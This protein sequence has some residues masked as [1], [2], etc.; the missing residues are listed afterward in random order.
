MTR[1]AFGAALA[2]LV[3][4]APPAGAGGAGLPDLVP[5]IDFR[6]GA[7]TVRRHQ[8]VPASDLAEGC[9]GGPTDRTLLRFSLTTE[10]VGTADLVLGDPGC[11]DCELLPGPTCENPLYEC[12]AV[13]GHGHGHF[14]QYAL[15]E[16]LPEPDGEVVAVGRKQ[17]FCLEDTLCDVRTYDC[18]YQGLAVGCQ[19]L[20]PSILGCQYVDVTDL[21]G[22]RYVLRATVN[23]ARLL[24]ESDY[25]N[26]VD[27]TTVDVCEAIPGPGASLK[28]T[29]KRPELLKWRMKGTAIV[30]AGLVEPDPHRDGARL[31]VET[32]SDP[33]VDLVIPGRPGSGHC[34]PKDG[35]KRRRGTFT[36]TN[37][38]GFLDR[39]CTAP[40][41]GLRKLK[42]T[43]KPKGDPPTAWKLKYRAK[44]RTLFPADPARLRTTLVLGADTG[45]CWTGASDCDGV[46]CTGD[47][48]SGAFVD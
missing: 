41:E 10:N 5:T 23:Y 26:N 18:E 34:G 45:P 36:Y 12:S 7:P 43:V 4:I 25:D 13:G 29:S 33:L 47:S 28:R 30:R 20:Y 44:G 1:L 37:Q 15:Y 14:S 19:D 42:V 2:A 27:E 6:F 17:G 22:G 31:R 16:V 9:A 21:P 35:W 3:A 32:D 40:A 8:R 11:P 24:P 39:D 38:S 48:A 46:R